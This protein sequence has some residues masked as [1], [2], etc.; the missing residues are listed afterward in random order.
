MSVASGDGSRIEEIAKVAQVPLAR[1]GTVG[2][3]RFVIEGLIDMPLHDLE[4]RW[5]NGLKEAMK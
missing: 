3:S 5:G 2:G 1:I 4:S